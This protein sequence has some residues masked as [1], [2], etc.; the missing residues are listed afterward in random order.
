MIVEKHNKTVIVTGANGIIGSVFCQM[1]LADG[2]QVAGFDVQ[3]NNLEQIQSDYPE[4]MLVHK[5][6]VRNKSDIESGLEKVL[7]KWGSVEGLFNNAAWKGE[8]PRDFFKAF[9]D[10]SLDSWQEIMSVNIDGVMLV[11][12]VVGS[13]MANVQNSGSIVHTAS[14][15]GVVAPDQRIYDGSFYLGGPINTPAAYSASKGAVLALTKYLATYWSGKGVRVNSV[16]PGGLESGQNNIFSEKYS[17][18]V[19]MQRMGKASE[20]VDSVLFL[21]SPK[22]SYING[23]NLIIDGGLT[24]W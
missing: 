24:V 5:T 8:E 20:I 9:E 14:I 15:Y 11:D 4:Q 21:L 17:N 12:Q 22:A 19:P 18:R 16:S 7:N 10:W 1:A 6:D 2:W 23:H 13:H 3:T